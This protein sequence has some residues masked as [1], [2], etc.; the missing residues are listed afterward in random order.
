MKKERPR[1]NHHSK[2]TSYVQ[3]L[4][5]ASNVSLDN[6]DMAQTLLDR[7]RSWVS[8]TPD[9][10][11]EL[12]DI[13]KA[14]ILERGTLTHIGKQERKDLQAVCEYLLSRADVPLIQEAMLHFQL[15]RITLR[16][17][18]RHRRA[19]VHLLHARRSAQYATNALDRLGSSLGTKLPMFLEAVKVLREDCE[20]NERFEGDQSTS[21][22]HTTS[23]SNPLPL[24]LLPGNTKE[25]QEH[26]PLEKRAMDESSFR[27]LDK[28]HAGT[29]QKKAAKAQGTSEGGKAHVDVESEPAMREERSTREALMR[30]QEALDLI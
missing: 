22:E 16:K 8:G 21:R 4:Q 12:T 11:R 1:S 23:Q 25:L 17:P 27:R 6:I 18:N 20:R 19:M 13:V 24:T 29:A 10:D 5:K 3:I 9:A 7:A 30:M 2:Q 14:I 26:E 28:L 15:A